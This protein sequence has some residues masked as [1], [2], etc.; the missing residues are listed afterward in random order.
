MSET[1][2]K[3]QSSITFRN[4]IN[5]IVYKLQ[6]GRVIDN[7]WLSQMESGNMLI[8]HIEDNRKPLLF[9]GALKTGVERELLVEKAQK[10]AFEKHNFDIKLPPRS[11]IDVSSITFEISGEDNEP[12]QAA[13]VILPS[14]AGGWQSLTLLMDLS[15]QKSDMLQSRI[16]FFFAI[17]VVMASLSVFGWQ[18]AGKAI[19]PIEASRRQQTEFVA[20]ASHELRSPLTVLG[21]S[22]SAFEISETENEKRRFL[23]TIKNECKRMSRLVDDLLLLASADAGTWSFRAG[24]VEPDTLI[25]NTYEAYE[26]IAKAKNQSL[27]LDL[28]DES[29]P[30]IKGDFQ[31]LSQALCCLLDNAVFYT[32]P[33]GKIILGACKTKR[34]FLIYVAD[35]GKGIPD[36]YKEK[37]FER[38]YRTDSSRSKKEHYGLGLSV[39]KEIISL[40][41]GK[42]YVKDT[43]GGG[44]TFFIE[45]T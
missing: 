26:E 24:E 17:T 9:R 25:I 15:M 16:K 14:S 43:K 2:L 3:N 29:L 11:S 18:F 33:G 45:F 36:E 27:I 20:A 31:R 6:S 8:I 40:H 35:N 10:V 28:P 23:N 5:S 21:V 12:Y 42:I 19:Q 39:A 13:A 34:T 1:Q 44:S 32:E 7:T 4:N 41:R 22:A 30:A 37:V 38:F